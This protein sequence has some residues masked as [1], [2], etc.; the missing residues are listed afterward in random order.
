MRGE[1]V[2]LAY[3][4]SGEELEY[5]HSCLPSRVYELRDVTGHATDL[6]AVPCTALIVR[7]GILDPDIGAFIVEGYAMKSGSA[8]TLLI[9]IGLPVPK[10]RMNAHFKPFPD[11][12][13]VREKLKFILL[14]AQK[15]AQVEITF[16][17]KV[18]LTLMALREIHDHP[19]ITT[20]ALS[21]KLEINPRSVQRCINSL[22]VAGEFVEYDTSLHGW[23][24][25]ANKSVLL[26]EF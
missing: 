21:E 23:R 15:N 11:F 19:G 20:K 9:W 8:T 2:I 13:T 4:L 22:R 6:V 18:A 10:G 14:T 24:L 25:L 3:G 26:G 7:A 12:D 16:S 17:K 5:V 1:P